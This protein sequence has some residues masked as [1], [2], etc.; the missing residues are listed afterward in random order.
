[1][2]AAGQTQTRILRFVESETRDGGD[3]SQ[4]EIERRF[5][6]PGTETYYRLEQLRLLGFI[7]KQRRED[8]EFAY[9]L[10]PDYRRELGLPPERSGP[11]VSLVS[12]QGTLLKFGSGNAAPDA[13]FFF[14][15]VRNSR[16]TDVG[17]VRAI[18][19]RVRRFDSNG[20][21][22]EDNTDPMPLKWRTGQGGDRCSAL[23]IGSR[24]EAV[25]ILG[26]IIEGYE[27]FQMDICKD[28]WPPG[29]PAAVH[30]HQRSQVEVIAEFAGG[31]RSPRL[32]IDI[33][34]DGEW[35]RDP[36]EMQ[37]HLRIGEVR[38]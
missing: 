7:D 8:R 27:F 23:R 15:R 5:T 33:T 28:P 4:S 25:A 12:P 36:A 30:T 2:S 1:L 29:Y 10:T 19:T 21:P 31:R 11:E 37:R 14:L 6:M 24:S 26:Y 17:G 20:V 9:R 34:W 16:D 32:S 18:I 22:I 35:H 38:G 13:F 3:V